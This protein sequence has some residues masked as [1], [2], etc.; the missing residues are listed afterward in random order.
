MTTINTAASNLYSSLKDSSNS[1]ASQSN[2]SALLD[3]MTGSKSVVQATKTAAESSYTLDLSPEAQQFLSQ[4]GSGSVKAL[5]GNFILTKKQEAQIAEVIAKY[6]DE[7][8]TKETYDQM[9]EELDALGLSP[10]ALAIKDKARGINTTSMLLAALNGTGGDLNQ[11]L[12]SGGVSEEQS[13]TKKDN[14]VKTILGKW[15]DVSTTIDDADGN[16]S[17]QLIES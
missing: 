2:T 16:D 7:P 14:Y 17:E 13:Q 9:E 8:F 4:N 6:K 5:D 1:A 11:T 10:Q 3:A 15:S 12:L